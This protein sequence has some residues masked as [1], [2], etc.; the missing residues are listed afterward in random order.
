MFDEYM[1]GYKDRLGE[2]L[3][4]R[5]PNVSPNTVTFLSL[6]TGVIAAIFLVEKWY[7][8]GL[9]VW[10]GSRLL[11]AVDGLLARVHGTQTDFGGYLDILADFVVYSIIPI[12]LVLANPT[13]ERYLALAF[14]LAVYYLNTASWMYLAAILEK[15]AIRDSDTRTTIVMP[16]G[17]I[18]GF[19]TFVAYVIFQLFPIYLSTWYLIFSLLIIVTILQRLVWAKNNLT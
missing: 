7:L 14:L 10:L 6:T 5:L 9:L 2:P 1:R 3:V 13:L 12:A 4:R 18:G 17:L 19:E 15:R 8:W 16:A 11:D